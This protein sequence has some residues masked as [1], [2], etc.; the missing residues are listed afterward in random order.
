[1]HDIKWIR[2]EPQGLVRALV[3]RGTDA[4]EAQALVDSLVALD[5]RRR[6]GIV[7]LEELQARRN[8]ASRRSAPP[9]RRRT[10]PRPKR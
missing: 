5:E 7:K 4:S 2:E 1:M 6:A 10:R 8:A 3:R 9:R